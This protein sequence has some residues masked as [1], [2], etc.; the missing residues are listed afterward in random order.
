MKLLI[1]NGPNINLLGKREPGIYGTQSF[2]DFF[3]NLQ[4]K[5]K[6]VELS[7]LIPTQMQDFYPSKVR[8]PLSSL[9]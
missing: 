2:E 4:F 6:D 1:I 8:Q 3:V 7:H 9:Y 5:Y